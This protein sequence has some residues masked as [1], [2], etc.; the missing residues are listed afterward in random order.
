MHDAVRSR[1]NSLVI[2]INSLRDISVGIHFD[3]GFS[4]GANVVGMT[5]ELQTHILRFTGFANRV[6]GNPRLYWASQWHTKPKCATSK[7]SAG[8]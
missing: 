3:F 7:P 6:W 8:L 1:Q 2:G 4:N 5:N